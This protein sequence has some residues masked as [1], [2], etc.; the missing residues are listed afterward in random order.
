MRFDTKKTF[1]GLNGKPL[2]ASGSEDSPPAE[3]GD[4]VLTLTLAEP[5]G[6]ATKAQMFTLARRTSETY[7]GEGDHVLE[8]STED[9]VI[10]KTQAEEYLPTLAYGLLCE[11]LEG[12]GIP[13]VQALEETA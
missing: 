7:F 9:V 6:K 2:L 13:N 12:G 8:L 10:I 3:L 11:V 4:V 1:T 5:K